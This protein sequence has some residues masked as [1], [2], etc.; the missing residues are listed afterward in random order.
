[1]NKRI[2]GAM[3]MA[4]L[5]SSP[6]LAAQNVG[7]TSQKGSLLIF[8]AVTIDP[9]N[10]SNTLIEISNDSTNPIQVEC[11]YVN[12]FKD[13]V[14]FDFFL[15]PKATASWDVLGRDGT[16]GP[17][18]FPTGGSP[19]FTNF[20][21]LPKDLVP[22][23]PFRGELICFAIKSTASGQAQVAFNHLIGTATVVFR[24]D[25]DAG[26]PR[27]AYRYN[28]WAFIA[29]NASGQAEAD[30]T[31][32]GTPGFLQLTGNGAGT[33]DACPKYNIA[34]FNPNRSTLGVSPDRVITLD[35]DLSVVSCNQDLRQDP[36][37][38][39]TMAQFT[40]WSADETSYTGTWACIDSIATIGLDSQDSS[41]VHDVTNFNVE[42][43]R[44]ANARFQVKGV[45]SAE[46]AG[47]QE[48]AGLLGVLTSSVDLDPTP[49][50][51]KDP[52]HQELGN[53]TS[54]AGAFPGFVMW[55]PAGPTAFKPHS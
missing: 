22:P 48:P 47:P 13:R 20:N 51:P 11:Y 30:Y 32:Q 5:F 8:P 39:L 49:Q 29:R 34:N 42:T 45:A 7:N 52:E 23:D 40:V 15:T 37:L 21:P 26:Q 46:C 17:A 18:P 9:E 50:D 31:V 6:A 33:Y 41:G 24:Q 44:T 54:G 36:V 38:H 10:A 2:L 16:I 27:Q 12:E 25:V 28:A 3:L 35:N 19:T 1:M 43:L 53:T 55:D 4:V 14:D